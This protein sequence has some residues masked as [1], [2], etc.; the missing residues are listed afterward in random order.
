MQGELQPIDRHKR[1][2]A[3]SKEPP[4]GYCIHCFQPLTPE[5]QKAGARKS[6]HPCL[7]SRLARRPASPPPYN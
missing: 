7:E 4:P 5:E 6:P 2:D 3:R 1:N